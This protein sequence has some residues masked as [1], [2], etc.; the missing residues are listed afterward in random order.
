LVPKLA[1]KV[2]FHLFL[3]I[4]REF[5]PEI[6]RI[7]AGSGNFSHFPAKQLPFATLVF[8]ETPRSGVGPQ[9]GV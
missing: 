3:P 9:R 5:I 8:A 7:G 2:S 6:I 1:S 4:R